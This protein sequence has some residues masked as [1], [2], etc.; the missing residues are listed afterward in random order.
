MVARCYIGLAV[1]SKV[2]LYLQLEIALFLRPHV[3]HWLS[4]IGVVVGPL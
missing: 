1:K 4:D 3:R 2:Y